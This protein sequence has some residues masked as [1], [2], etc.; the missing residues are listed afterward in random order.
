MAEYTFKSDLLLGDKYPSHWKLIR[1]R[2]LLKEEKEIV[3]SRVD[4]HLLSLTKTGIIFRDVES[5]KGKFPKDFE[6][7]KVVYP[8]NIIF[9]LFDID[10]TPRTVG[11]S[12]IY[13]MITGAY[14]VFS[15]NTKITNNDYLYYYFLAVDNI[16]GLRPYYSGLRKVV[17]MTKFL[18]IQIPIPP[19]DEQ[20]KIVEYLSEVD[21]N[22]AKL[23]S[24]KKKRI[25]LQKELLE[26]LIFFGGKSENATVNGWDSNFPTEW[27]IVK[28]KRIFDEIDLKGFDNERFI[29]VTQ[30]KA[31]IYKDQGDVNFVTASD[32]KTQKLVCPGQFVIS[33]RSFQGGLELSSIRGVISPAYYVFK[34]KNNY[35]T[36]EMRAFF[37]FLFKSRPYISLLNSLSDSLRD[38]KSI[39][40]NEVADFNY[41]LPS[42][43]FLRSFYNEVSKYDI[44]NEEYQ[45]LSTLLTEYKQRLIADAVTGQIKID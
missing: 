10:E 38:G 30:D 6:S 45:K 32:T 25:E 33:L 15:I 28:G 7:Y 44:L 20:N 42:T 40:F 16:K 2:N 24:E 14:D 31:L 4:L 43:E 22:I 19:F 34:L 21:C 3:G 8:N 23:L 37:R 36:K 12:S 5:G 9:C 41:P 27:N 35:D 29:A 1:A 18:S 39:K 11:L 26:N 13:G 17:Q